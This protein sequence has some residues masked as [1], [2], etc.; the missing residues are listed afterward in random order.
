MM[1]LEVIALAGERRNEATTAF[2]S[3]TDCEE[4][5][6]QGKGAAPSGVPS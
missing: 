1:G 3:V 2:V 4:L 5:G 6:I